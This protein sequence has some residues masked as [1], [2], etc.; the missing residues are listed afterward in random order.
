[1]QTTF[2]GSNN[3]AREVFNVT[4]TLPPNMIEN[5]VDNAEDME[6]VREIIPN[7]EECKN[8][9]PNED[10]IDNLGVISDLHDIA[11]RLRGENKAAIIAAIEKLEALQIDVYHQS[12][13][14][15]SE[16][17]KALNVLENY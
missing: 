13:Y 6:A 8:T 17:T 5:L 4:G 3:T 9:F 11:R 1:M 14:G 12:E 16:L 2:Y 10:F 15:R 7:I